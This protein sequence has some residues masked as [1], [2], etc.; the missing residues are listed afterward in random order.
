MNEKYTVKIINNEKKQIHTQD[1][2]ALDAHEAHKSIFEKIATAASMLQVEC[3]VVGG[4][5]RDKILGRPTKDIDV[6]CV[7][8]GIALAHETSFLFDSKPHVS[9][10]KNYGTAQQLLQY[11]KHLHGYHRRVR[12]P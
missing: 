3:Y 10:F 5:V 1:V 11:G 8:D 9:F 2:S 6:V 4:F 12:C 7:G